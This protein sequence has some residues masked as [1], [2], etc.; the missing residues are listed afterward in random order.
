MPLEAIVQDFSVWA[1]ALIN[2]FGYIGIFVASFVGSAS[3]ILP[4]PVFAL[5]FSAGAILN[6]VL[7]GIFAGVG[8]GLGELTGYGIGFAGNKTIARY[9]KKHL[10]WFLLAEKW[11][12]K[13]R[14][15][16]IIF[17]F[18]ASPLPDDIIGILCGIMKYPVK[19]FIIA[20]ILGKITLSLILAFSGFYSINWLSGLLLY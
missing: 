4:V 17:I 16:W 19:K 18:A 13:H 8:S 10:Q 3:V 6:P 11:F 14:G 12:Q 15:F 2:G 20:S 9:K 5:I 1:S 7:V